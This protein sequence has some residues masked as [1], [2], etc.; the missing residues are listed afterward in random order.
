[1][2]IEVQLSS[3][4]LELFCGAEVAF[5]SQV[6]ENAHWSCKSQT[7]QYCILFAGG[8][9]SDDKDLGRPAAVLCFPVILF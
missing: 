7:D 9:E 5:C 6:V 2:P 3:H 8:E 1:M 4:F